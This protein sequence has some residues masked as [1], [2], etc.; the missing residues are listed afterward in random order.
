[1]LSGG[2]GLDNPPNRLPYAKDAVNL[3]HEIYL[4]L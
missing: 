3:L 4:G 2:L 1:M